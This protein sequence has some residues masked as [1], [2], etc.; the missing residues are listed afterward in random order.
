MFFTIISKV[1]IIAND[2]SSSKMFKIFVIGAILYILLH[3]YLFIGDRGEIINKYKNYIYYVMGI[4]FAIAYALSVMSSSNDDEDEDDEKKQKP[5]QNE[6]TQEQYLRQLA[7]RNQ[8][9]EQQ[10]AMQLAQRVQVA[11]EK[12]NSS[13]Q[14]DEKNEETKSA[15]SKKSSEKKEKAKK[16]KSSKKEK[17][18]ENEDEDTALPIYNGG[19]DE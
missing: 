16:S 18:E 5:N 12:S 10:R 11:Q 17:K 13:N 3:Y 14:K 2:N 7:L 8:M 4:D 9:L 6:P 1:P 15:S 19:D